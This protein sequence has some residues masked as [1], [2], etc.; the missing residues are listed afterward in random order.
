MKAI[1]VYFDEGT[2]SDIVELAR[3]KGVSA[4]RLVR[5]TA[6]LILEAD[7]DVIAIDGRLAEGDEEAVVQWEDIKASLRSRM[8]AS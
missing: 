2:H 8:E 6:I 1:T 7:L 5:T 4:S 3:R